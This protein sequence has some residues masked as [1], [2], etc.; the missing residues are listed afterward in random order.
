MSKQAIVIYEYRGRQKLLNISEISRFS[1]LHPMM[2]QK[3]FRLGLID[4]EVYEPDLLFEDT[5]LARINKIMRIKND[6]G[7]NLGGCGLVLDLLDKIA[8]LERRLH[9]YERRQQR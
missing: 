4:P 7:V 3:L 6:L 5:V 2:I 8:E 9:Y 1:G